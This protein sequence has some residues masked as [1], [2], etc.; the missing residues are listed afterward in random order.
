[1][2]SCGV[3]YA[4]VP[5]GGETALDAA[6]KAAR[7]VSKHSSPLGVLALDPAQHAFAIVDRWGH[8]DDMPMWAEEPDLSSALELFALSEAVGEVVAFFD[9]DD[10]TE[11][12]VYGA[13]KHGELV[14]ELM[15]AGD[16]W[17]TVEGAPQP[18]EAPLFAPESLARA[19]EYPQGPE[20]DIRAAFAA[21]Q[22][23]AGA[24]WPVPD[25]LAVPIR[26][27]LRGPAYGFEPWPRRKELVNQNR[28]RD[29]KP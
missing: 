25:G 15:W 8:R 22:L 7:G 3:V 13:W 20:S 23:A 10:G 6:V 16:H 14:R 26:A 24:R 9:V 28:E 12:G 29:A 17:A 5:V 11:F 2:G 19:L 4:K 21:G 18:W 1:M 27:I